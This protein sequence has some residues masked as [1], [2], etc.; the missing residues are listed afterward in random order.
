MMDGKPNILFILSDALRARDMSC[1]GYAKLTTPNLDRLAERGVLFE[2]AYSCT[3]ETEI[4]L[5]SIFSGM[6]PP[7][8]G[9]V[10]ARERYWRENWRRIEANR[11]RFLP[12]IL[13]LNGYRTIGIDWLG[14]WHKKGYDV[15]T[16]RPSQRSL[17][18]FVVRSL[19]RYPMVYEK[20]HN[21]YYAFSKQKRGGPLKFKGD[22]ARALTNIALREI[23]RSGSKPFFMFIH[24]W[25]THIPFLKMKERVDS[26]YEGDGRI[27]LED[28]FRR[29]ENREYRDYMRSWTEGIEYLEE[30]MAVYEGCINFVDEQVGRL[31]ELLE[32]LGILDDTIIVF[33]SDHGQSFDKHHIFYHSGMYEEVLHVP[34]LLYYERLDGHTRVQSLVQNIDIMPT[35]L[36]LA[37]LPGSRGMDGKSVVESMVSGTAIR[38]RVYGYNAFEKAIRE[39]DYKLIVEHGRKLLF[40]LAEDPDEEVNVLEENMDVA[41]SLEKKLESWERFHR[42]KLHKER[43]KQKIARLKKNIEVSGGKDV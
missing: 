17:L 3:N 35:L 41:V 14:R 19:K 23:K 32:E 16:D 26:F 40:N 39:G 20:L 28:V 2:K 36:E 11:I 9:V 24:Y 13:R 1:Y 30:L 18:K 34:L 43:L 4:S 22:D 10:R 6:Y 5:T 15:Y 29:I 31:L 7:T 42:Q 38:E 8:H 27:R 25:D 12:E 21:L 37:G 33:T